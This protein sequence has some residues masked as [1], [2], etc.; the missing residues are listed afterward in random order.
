MNDD[1]RRTFEEDSG[2]DISINVTLGKEVESESSAD[3]NEVC[4]MTNFQYWNRETN[5]FST[6]NFDNAWYKKIVSLGEGAVPTIYKIIKKTPHPIVQALDE[7]YPGT[8]S[9]KGNVTL[10]EVCEAWTTTLILLGKI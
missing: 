6:N 2:F 1:L 8:M 5:L 9:Y 10:E 4:V 3:L 7:I